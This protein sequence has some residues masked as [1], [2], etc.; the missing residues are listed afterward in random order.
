MYYAKSEDRDK[1]THFCGVI[2]G[3]ALLAYVPFMLSS[4]VSQ[5]T[6]GQILHE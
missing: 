2:S 3:S 4:P 5:L 1:T 6:Y